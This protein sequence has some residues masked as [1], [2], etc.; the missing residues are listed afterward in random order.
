MKLF[1]L[2]L[3]C[4]MFL[5]GCGNVSK[6]YNY[7]NNYNIEIVET[8]GDFGDDGSFFIATYSAYNHTEDPVTAKVEFLVRISGNG[9]DSFHTFNEDIIIQ[10]GRKF[11]SIEVITHVDGYV[12]WARVSD[13]EYVEIETDD[14]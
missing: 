9:Y 11:S 14:K 6:V 8:H 13:I 7:Q 12:E 2:G 10:P 3:S 4:L 5:T 1:L